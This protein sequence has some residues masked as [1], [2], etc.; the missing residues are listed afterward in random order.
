M[1]ILF[2][3]LGFDPSGKKRVIVQLNNDERQ[4]KNLC[5]SII[6]AGTGL[7]VYS[8]VVKSSGEVEGWKG[9]YFIEFDFSGYKKEGSYYFFLKTE[10]D[11]IFSPSFK[12]QSHLY[13]DSCISDI[14]FYFKSQR[15]SG[16]WDRADRSVPIWKER[17]AKADVHGGW[18]D[19]SGDY[20]KYLSHL[21]YAHYFNPQQIPLVVWSLLE[22]GEKLSRDEKYRNFLLPERALEEAFWGADF[23]M[24]MRD[25]EGFFYTTVFDRWSKKTEER[26]IS[27]FRTQRGERLT[28]HQAGFRQGGGISIAALARASKIEVYQETKGEYCSGEYLEAA[29]SAYAHLKTENRNYLDNGKENI[30]DYYTGLLAAA[31]LFKASKDSFYLAESRFWSKMLMDLYDHKTSCFMVEMDSTRPYF[32]ASDAGLPIVALVEYCLL[33]VDG[34]KR[35]KVAEFLLRI[36]R[37][38]AELTS[39]VYN[40]FCLY[41]KMV[42]SI[43]GETY[44]SFFIPHENETGYWWQGENAGLASISCGFRKALELISAFDTSAGPEFKEKMSDLADSQLHWILGCNPFDMCMLQGRGRNNPEYEEYHPN[45]PG[46][47]CNGITAGFTD[48]KDLAF[49]PDETRGRGDHKWRWSE[50]WIP[51]AAWFLLA[52]AADERAWTV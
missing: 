28:H 47:I 15:C 39:K 33:E 45:A 41:R 7:T 6:D 9:R 24:R 34:S 11:T 17:K 31:E 46:G 22:L 20:S 19:A 36:C 10:G 2:N 16:K 1:Q 29:V 14:L 51:H 4:D 44:E 3:H 21:S 42:R 38:I 8:P 52:L 25:P 37:D 27:S 18:F 26:I 5:L 49:L 50:Q 43:D 48:E 23:L 13:R 30:I 32:H 35:N 40:P 12:I